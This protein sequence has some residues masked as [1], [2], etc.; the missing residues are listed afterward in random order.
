MKKNNTFR[1][2]TIV[3]NNYFIKDFSAKGYYGCEINR[4]G[5]A[6]K[7]TIL[8]VGTGKIAKMSNEEFSEMLARH[9]VA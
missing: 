8:W 2:H 1:T 3:R 7:H 9:K 6:E 5:S 4:I